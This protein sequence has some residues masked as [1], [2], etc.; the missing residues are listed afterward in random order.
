[1]SDTCV[2][3]IMVHLA[4]CNKNNLYVL[5]LI[6][7]IYPLILL[8]FFAFLESKLIQKSASDSAAVIVLLFYSTHQHG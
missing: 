8:F 1:M 7:A 4:F 5:F 2:F 3:L 6:P